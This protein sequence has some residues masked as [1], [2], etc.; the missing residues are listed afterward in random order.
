MAVNP[1]QRQVVIGETLIVTVA[2]SVSEGCSFPILELTLEQVGDDGPVFDYVSPSTH[3]VGPPVTNPFSYTLSATHPG[4]V[5]F[6][7]QAY[8]ERYCGDFWNWTYVSGESELVTVAE[9]PHRIH[10]PLIGKD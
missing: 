9:Q 3:T 6:D 10:M 7:G 4:T 2:I 5:V 1:S 8:G